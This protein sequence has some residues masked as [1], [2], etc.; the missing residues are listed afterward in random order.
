[1]ILKVIS[2]NVYS[3]DNTNKMKGAICGVLTKG[4]LRRMFGIFT[5]FT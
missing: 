4:K 2:W 1:M 3:F 5:Y